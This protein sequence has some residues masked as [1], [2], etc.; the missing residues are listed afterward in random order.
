MKNILYSAALVTLVVFSSC[1]KDYTCECTSKDNTGASYGTS[2][3]TIHS[4][5][6]DAESACSA[7]SS[8]SAG[9]MTVTQTCE[10][11]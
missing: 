8:A 6:K 11:K 10:I 5:K 2:S 9:G 3:V 1:K 7:T 4:T